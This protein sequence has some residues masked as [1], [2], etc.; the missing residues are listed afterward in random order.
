MNQFNLI[1]DQPPI[2]ETGLLLPGQ[3]VR[4]WAP[5]MPLK[6]RQRIGYLDEV[7]KIEC[8]RSSIGFD[9][10]K[11]YQVMTSTVRVFRYGSKLMLN[12]ETHQ[13]ELTSNEMV[14]FV[15]DNSGVPRI[16]MDEQFFGDDFTFSGGAVPDH[17]FE[18]LLSNFKIPDVPHVGALFPDKLALATKRLRELEEYIRLKIPGFAFKADYQIEDFPLATLRDGVILAHD[19]GLGKTLASYTIPLIKFGWDYTTAGIMPKVPVLIVCL[20]DLV[21]QTQKEGKKYYGI[22]T[23]HLSDPSKFPAGEMPNGFYCCTYHDLT[24]NA[25]MAAMVGKAFT[26]A[27]IVDEGTKIKAVDTD[28]ALAVRSF[29]PKFRMVVTATPFKNRLRDMFFL[30]AWTAGGGQ[31]SHVGWPFGNTTSELERFTQTFSVVER[32]LT[33]QRQN[34]ALMKSK[35]T[36]K[37]IAQVANIYRLWKMV[38]PL[39]I[40]RRK[41]DSL[42]GLV[43]KVRHE[44]YVPMGKH[45][46]EVYLKHLAFRYQVKGT[47]RAAV[48]K[49]LTRLRQASVCPES[50]CLGAGDFKSNHPFTPKMQM[51]LSLIEQILARNE[52]VLVFAPFNDALDTISEYL[53]L[54]KVRHH[55]VNGREDCTLRAAKVEHFKDPANNVPVLLASECSMAY[56]YNLSRCNNVIVLGLEWAMDIIIQAINRGHRA[57]SVEDVNV[58]F[59]LAKGSTDI[60]QYKLFVQKEQSSDMILDGE[61]CKESQTSREM[62]GDEMADIIQNAESDF[63]ADGDLPVDEAEIVKELPALTERLRTAAREWAMV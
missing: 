12:Q 2:A 15:V 7:K 61:S 43:K 42:A 21:N 41:E 57:D 38:V 36:P 58:Y 32:D 8:C 55:I 56:G 35:G 59:V 49:T 28:I 4:Q 53:R 40:R 22:K 45:Q 1:F 31:T 46:R 51:A 24:R 3:P 63:N 27:V 62:A 10:G 34:L 17:H 52:Q 26:K 47:N 44:I 30:C 39:I 60:R 19:T 48:G 29:T 6:P 20:G 14:V 13:V 50:N 54:A 18:V 16:Y 25:K 23:T 37:P 33:R 5:L 11:F 9:A